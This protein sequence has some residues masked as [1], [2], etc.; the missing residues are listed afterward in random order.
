MMMG[1]KFHI[2]WPAKQ[3]KIKER[4]MKVL[5]RKYLDV[6]KLVNLAPTIT[7]TEILVPMRIE[8]GHEY[9]RLRDEFTWSFNGESSVFLLVNHGRAADDAIQIPS[10]PPNSSDRHHNLKS[11]S[12]NAR[13]FFQLP[14]PRP[15]KGILRLRANADNGP[16]PATGLEPAEASAACVE[17]GDEIPNE[18]AS[19]TRGPVD[20]PVDSEGQA[21]ML[22]PVLEKEGAD[23]IEGLHPNMIDGTWHCSNC[24]YPG[25]MA[26]GRRKGPLGQGT[27]CGECVLARARKPRPV[28]YSTSVEYHMNLKKAV[29]MK[30]RGANANLSVNASK[31]SS[32]RESERPQVNDIF[33]NGQDSLSPSLPPKPPPLPFI[34]NPGSPDSTIGPDS[35]KPQS[36]PLPPPPPELPAST[37]IV[38][39]PPSPPSPKNPNGNTPTMAARPLLMASYS[40]DRVMG[41]T[42]EVPLP[43]WMQDC[44]AATQSRYPN[45]R[46]GVI[47]GPRLQNTEAPAMPKFRL[48]CL[49]CP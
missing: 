13:E 42:T 47:L 15:P 43:Q 8:I 24:G 12:V 29:K 14:P 6:T 46:V 9:Y 49:D 20:Q 5:G 1:G 45:G 16:T 10:L 31:P 23:S 19:P 44:L 26:V 30:K 3:R 35:P 18:S 48:K 21:A 37:P 17:F 11:Q 7:Q 27:M 40:S 28:E 34:I 38:E 25:S 33:T 22:R 32:A 2:W 4:K 41:Q 39:Q 36:T